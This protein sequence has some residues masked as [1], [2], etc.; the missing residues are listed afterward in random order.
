M[1]NSKKSGLLTLLFIIPFGLLPIPNAHSYWYFYDLALLQLNKDSYPEVCVL[2]DDIVFKGNAYSLTS[3]TYF[4]L[5][6]LINANGV[7]HNPLN[8]LL[9]K[10]SPKYVTKAYLSTGDLNNDGHI[11]I[12]ATTINRNS[13]IILF[14]KADSSGTFDLP[15]VTEVG[16]T[17]QKTAIG[18]LNADGTNDIAVAGTNENLIILLNDPSNP[19]RQ[20]IPKS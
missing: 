11:D 1:K 20:F 10:D 3:D 9:G 12:V 4:Y 16:G 18:D 5:T 6:T 7:F 14:Q 13:V 17:P 8:A 19:G 2:S 15:L